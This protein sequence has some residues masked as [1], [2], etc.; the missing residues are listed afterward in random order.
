MRVISDV[1]VHNVYLIRI[2]LELELELRLDT[3]I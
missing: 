1:K 3:I 2:N